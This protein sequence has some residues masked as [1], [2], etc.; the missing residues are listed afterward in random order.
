MAHNIDDL[1]TMTHYR[2]PFTVTEHDD[3]W[4]IKAGNR[5]LRLSD[6]EAQE[7]ADIVNGRP[8]IQRFPAISRC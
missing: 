6:T 4:L 8:T 1:R 5:L 7:L 2:R 3:G